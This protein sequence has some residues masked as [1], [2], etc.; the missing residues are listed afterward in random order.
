[1]TKREDLEETL[2]QLTATTLSRLCGILGLPRGGRKDERMSRLLE[3]SYPLSL[4]LDLANNSLFAEEVAHLA[5]SSFYEE[6][7]SRQGLPVGGTKEEKIWR[8]IENNVFDPE[9][10]LAD[11][12]LDKLREVYYEIHGQVSPLSREETAEAILLAYGLGESSSEEPK[13][14]PRGTEASFVFILMPFRDDMETLYRE[15]IKP[16][17]EGRGFS[18]YRADDFFT[19]NKIMDDIEVAI[20]SAVFVIADLSGRNPNVF[21][22]VGMSHAKRKRVILL[23]QKLEDVPF[24]LRP[25]RHIVYQNDEDGRRKLVKVLAKTV[26]TVGRELE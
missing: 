26:Q 2:E 17:V 8:L 13:G 6:E 7:L 23:T 12:R 24:D 9:A 3:S 4:V 5:S 16:T 18:C 22:E 15:V 19:A 14:P 20:D 11:I 10:G 21:Y 25:W 1:M